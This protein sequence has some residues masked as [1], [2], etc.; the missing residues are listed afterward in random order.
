MRLTDLSIKAL[1]APESGAIIYADDTLTGFGVRVSEGGTKSFVLTHGVRRQRLTIGRVGVLGL[2]EARLAAKKTL[3]EYTLGKGR[4]QRV[5][6]NTAKVEYLARVKGACK[7]RTYLDYAWYLDTHFRFGETIMDD[8]SQAELQRKLDKLLDRP[9][10]HG[11]A[12]AVLRGF[13]RWAYRRYYL[14]INPMARMEPPSPVDSR[15]RTLTDDE[16]V[17]VWSAAGEL[18]TF[19]LIVRGLILTGQRRGEVTKLQDTMIGDDCITLPKEFTKNNRAHKFPVGPM[20]LD[21][22]PK[23]TGLLFPADG[24]AKPF[25]G[26][27]KCKAALDECSGVSN[28]RLHDLRRTLRTKWAELGVPKEVAEKY[29]N[30]IS[31]V[32]S[33]V[34]AVYDRYNYYSEMRAAV[35]KW[36]GHLQELLA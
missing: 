4:A 16:L 11:C 24:S 32:H 26:F 34:N 9:A 28:W 1:K 31:G 14:E 13:I 36:E 19:G 21:L 8:L 33:G 27:S 7:E 30:H 5:P 15:D 29:I 17:R 12:Y 18:N 10:L 2:Q 25:S 35:D 20:T 6:W 22:L 3:A 23:R